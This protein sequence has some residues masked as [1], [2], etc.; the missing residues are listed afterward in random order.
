M[1][2]QQQNQHKEKHLDSGKT[3]TKPQRSSKQ[4]FLERVR[5]SGFIP[6]TSYRRIKLP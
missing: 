6:A 4:I 1:A 2:E 5:F 3:K